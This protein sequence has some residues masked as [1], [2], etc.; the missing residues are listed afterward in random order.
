MPKVLVVEIAPR[1]NLAFLVNP[2][3]HSYEVCCDVR[4]ILI[5]IE[6]NERREFFP[7]DRRV[8]SQLERCR[9][10]LHEGIVDSCVG[11][12]R[13]RKEIGTHGVGYRGGHADQDRLLFGGK[14][15]PE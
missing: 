1:P 5:H 15:R 13:L 6:I 9:V 12:R 2:R 14:R 10:A 11:R 3:K 7:L 8:G 4:V